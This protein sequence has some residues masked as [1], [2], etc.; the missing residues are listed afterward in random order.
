MI[1]FVPGKS[2]NA[3][4]SKF[5]SGGRAGVRAV[6]KSKCAMSKARRTKCSSLWLALAHD[7][8]HRLRSGISTGAAQSAR[9]WALPD[10]ES[11][12]MRQALSGVTTSDVMHG[13]DRPTR[14]AVACWTFRCSSGRRVATTHNGRGFRRGGAPTRTPITRQNALRRAPEIA[15]HWRVRGIS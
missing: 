15:S 6:L 10:T 13:R 7:A 12:W 11:D 14:T 5:S 8:L 2:R 1:K 4:T 9:S 3:A